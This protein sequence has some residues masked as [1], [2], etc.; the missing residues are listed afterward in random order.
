MVQRP[1]LSARQ[2]KM[3]AV[4]AALTV[5]FAGGCASSE[6]DTGADASR[7]AVAG[8]AIIALSDG[9]LPYSAAAD[10]L[11]RPQGFVPTP[12][13]LTRIPLPLPDPGPSGRARAPISSVAVGNAAIGPARMMALRGDGRRA[14]VL[15][16]FGS[17][18]ADAS[19]IRDLS[20]AGLVT[21][22]DIGSASP[23][24]LGAVDVGPGATTISSTVAGDLA[25]VARSAPGVNELVFLGVDD[26]GPRIMTRLP[27]AE[28]KPEP[29]VRLA[30][31]ALRPDGSALALTVLGGDAA[32]VY[33]VSRDGNTV[34]VK[35][36]GPPV[37]TGNFPYVCAWTPDGRRLVTSD[38]NWG[39]A[40]A[41]NP[42][43]A[44][45]SSMSV[46]RINEDASPDAA[47]VLTSQIETGVNAE[48]L[49]VSPVGFDASRDLIAV[50]NLRR[51]FLPASD[52]AFTRG[53]SVML[54]TI[55]RA[56]GE[57]AI[58]GEWPCAAGPKGVAFDA[59]GGV[60]LVPDYEEGV[61]QLW[62]VNRAGGAALTYT[63]VRLGAPAGVHALA[64]AP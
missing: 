9:D 48:G 22:V 11:L 58:L 18:A 53:G 41:F 64:V 3:L 23:R 50:G 24:A 16:T 28:F 30:C 55:D 63:G 62:R 43:G 33:R 14:L 7:P 40:N 46:I 17:P 29:D 36:W 25:V 37:R 44:P 2:A 20:P 42:V 1:V 47:H 54:A 61:I 19:T 34:S 4:A 52:P 31:V 59:R 6:V 51:S 45:R 60:L 39:G 38:L 12:D 5:S 27:I 32:W 13:T 10:L 26:R 57:A 8:S 21:L 49:A 35:P 15:M 56:T